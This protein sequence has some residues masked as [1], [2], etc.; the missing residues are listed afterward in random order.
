MIEECELGL[1]RKDDVVE[2]PI[3]EHDDSGESEDDPSV[4]G[5]LV[6][7]VQRLFD[8]ALGDLEVALDVRQL[9]ASN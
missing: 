1:E 9:H 7:Q 2:Q 6:V 5:L 4:F 3:E 8:V